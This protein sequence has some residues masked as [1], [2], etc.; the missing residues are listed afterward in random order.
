MKPSPRRP[1][2]LDSGSLAVLE[3]ERPGVGGVPAHL[4]VGLADLVAGGAVGDDQVGDLLAP[5]DLAGDGG[6]RDAAGDLGAGVGD[7][8]LGAVDRP[9]AVGELGAGADV[10][11]VGAGLGL[12]QAEGGE[13]LAAAQPR[14]PFVLLLVAAPEVD[15]HRPQRGVGGHR[16]ADRGVDPRQLFHRQHVGE[17]VGPAAAVLL[18]ERNPHQPQ[19]PELLDDLVGKGLGPVQLLRHR[20]DLLAAQSHGPCP[21]AVSARLK[22][23]SSCRQPMALRGGGV[24][25]P[26]GACLPRPQDPPTRPRTTAAGS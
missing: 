16:D 17:R 10:A 5:V 15:R 24:G 21:A 13:A 14:Q 4:A 6:D 25:G 12:G 2:R 26:N 3:G 7:E 22:A 8:L 9:L 18:R 1:S 19:P 11:G 23:R 20:L